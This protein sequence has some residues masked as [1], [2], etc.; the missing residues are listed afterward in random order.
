MLK[1]IFAVLYV[2][3]FYS[4][5]CKVMSI[6]IGFDFHTTYLLQPNNHNT[7]TNNNN[8]HRRGQWLATMAATPWFGVQTPVT[9]LN[10][11][12]CLYVFLVFL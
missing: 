11:E 10:Y 2:D 1:S 6:Q 8:S 3:L 4:L 5:S 12:T 7:T 9:P